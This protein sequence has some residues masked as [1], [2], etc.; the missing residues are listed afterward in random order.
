MNDIFIITT[1]VFFLLPI[2]VYFCVKFGTFGY[3]SGRKSYKLYVEETT[4]KW[5][6][7]E[8]MKEEKV[9]PGQEQ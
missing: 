8:E 2:C 9:Q 1:M 4:K 6:E 3:L 5:H 7:K